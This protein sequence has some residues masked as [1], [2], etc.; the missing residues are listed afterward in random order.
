MPRW[1]CS[2][3]VGMLLVSCSAEVSAVTFPSARLDELF[4]QA[5]SIAVVEL[6]GARM[7]AGDSPELFTY[8]L[9]TIKAF[10]GETPRMLVNVADRLAMGERY[11]ILNFSKQDPVIF[12]I[13][14]LGSPLWKDGLWITL[15]PSTIASP[16]SFRRI[17]ITEYCGVKAPQSDEWLNACPGGSAFISWD[18]V[19][20]YLERRY[21]ER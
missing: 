7:T 17:S 3:F 12:P 8:Q 2:I 5:S 1:L 11:L 20:S 10:E 16:A 19:E 9:R 18:D 21:E 15:R 13:V 14:E 4:D 6:V